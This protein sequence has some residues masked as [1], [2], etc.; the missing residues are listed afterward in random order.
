MGK[1][2][3]WSR[4][5]EPICPSYLTVIPWRVD[6]QATRLSGTGTLPYILDSYQ[7]AASN[8]APNG[9]GRASD[10]P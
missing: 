7:P 1:K 6:R 9:K 10:A 3:D 5:R 2:E 8:D 4:N